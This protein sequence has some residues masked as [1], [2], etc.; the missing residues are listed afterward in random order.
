MAIF[1]LFSDFTSN[2]GFKIFGLVKIFQKNNDFFF[3]E[4]ILKIDDF[5]RFLG[6]YGCLWCF[7][8][9]NSK[10]PLPPKSRSTAVS[11]ESPMYFEMCDFR[12]S[13]SVHR[14][15]LDRSS[16]E[17]EIFTNGKK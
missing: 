6:I 8:N 9:R 4:R 7:F 16:R 12:N 17:M 3:G 10:K 14:T 5:L 15:Q 11:I 13:T 2:S 1:D